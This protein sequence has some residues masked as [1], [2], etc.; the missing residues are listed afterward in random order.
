MIFNAET[1]KD[2]RSRKS[3]HYRILDTNRLYEHEKPNVCSHINPALN[4]AKPAYS[5]F[6]GF[7][8]GLS[9]RANGRR[10]S[11]CILGISRYISINCIPEV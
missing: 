7:I 10:A 2:I 6:A 8:D 1:H 5:V 11:A 3:G 9:H 4:V